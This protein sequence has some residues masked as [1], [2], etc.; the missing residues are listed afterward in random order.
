MSTKLQGL[1]AKFGKFTH[2]VD[3]EV[4][5]FDSKLDGVSARL[6]TTFSGAHGVVDGFTKHFDDVDAIVTEIEK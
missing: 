6:P 2:D 1:A 5:K 4:D 3:Y